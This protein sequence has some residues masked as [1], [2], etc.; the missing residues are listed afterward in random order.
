[1]SNKN[2]PLLSFDLF[3]YD[4]SACYPRILKS[5]GF[6]LN[7]IDLNNKKERNIYIGR[8]QRDHPELSSYLRN[9]VTELLNYYKLKNNLTNNNIVVEQLDGF[10][11]N[12]ELKENKSSFLDLDF[13][14]YVDF[15]ILTP[16][17]KKFLYCL[18]NEIYVKGISN[19]YDN[20]WKVYNKFLNL[21]FFDKV[22]LYKQMEQ[23]KT[24]VLNCVDKDF[25]KIKIDEKKFV[26]QTIDGQRS[27]SG[28]VDFDIN[29]LNKRKYFDHY[30]FEFLQSI[31][32]ET[33]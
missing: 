28:N 10:I 14:G 5:L 27:I 33:S 21:N 18:D 8:L 2:V 9:T 6:D 30:F 23:I 13:R 12:K 17:K 32:F 22:S 11:V 16:D 29:K 1:M 24:S 20:L 4:F 3:F 25:F 15:L 7:G 19:L 26:I 31:V